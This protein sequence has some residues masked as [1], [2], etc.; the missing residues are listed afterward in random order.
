MLLASMKSLIKPQC[1]FRKWW[2]KVDGKNL[3]KP[4]MFSRGLSDASNLLK[5]VMMNQNEYKKST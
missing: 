5:L 2:K 1:Y 4:D 3:T